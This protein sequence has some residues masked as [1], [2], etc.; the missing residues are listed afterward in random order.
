M[1]QDTTESPVAS[2]RVA[3]VLAKRILSGEILPGGRIKQDEIATEFGI[4]RIPVREA[5][6]I[7]EVRGLVTLQANAGARAVTLSS[8]EMEISYEI[9]ERLEPFLL[10]DSMPNLTD[11]D[12]ADMATIKAKLDAATDV[13]EFLA[14]NRDF[15]WTAF[16]GHTSPLLAQ[17]VE[18]FWDMTHNYRRAYAKLVLQDAERMEI[19]RAER[20]LLFG[21]IR[22]RELDLAPRLL[23]I[24]IRRTHL[25]LLDFSDQLASLAT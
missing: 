6:R 25:G 11:D 14:L 5:L 16:R 19:M 24:H 3:D 2:Q 15:H 23:A 9:R 22:R 7:L 1:Q 13:D 12:I 20:D 4:S 17:E 18:R 8:R 21:A 10:V